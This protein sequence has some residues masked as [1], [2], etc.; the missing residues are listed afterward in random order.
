MT[1]GSLVVVGTGIKL[2]A[3]LTPEA[4]AAIIGADV[5]FAVVDPVALHWLESLNAEVVSLQPLYASERSRRETYQAMTET[6]LSAVR[7]GR[8]VCA[9][10]YGHPG[11]FVL[12]ARMSIARARDEGFEAH[13]LP[14]ISAEDCLIADLGVDPGS[15]WQSYE[16]HDYFIHDRTIDPTAPLVLWQISVVGDLSFTAFDTDARRLQ[17]LSAVLSEIYPETHEVIVYEAATLPIHQAGI[18]R[19]ALRDLHTAYVVQ[20]ST[21]FVPPLKAPERSE[22]RMAMLSALG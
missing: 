1:V 8:N 17:L 13:M 21:L 15:G 6:V 20:Q 12:P 18:Q 14:G 9:A 5:V 16:A 10:F 22:K 19:V 4:E 11:V 3:Q 7:S 2:G